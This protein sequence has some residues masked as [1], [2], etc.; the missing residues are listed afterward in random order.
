MK[1][2]SFVFC[3]FVAL[4]GQA[5]FAKPESISVSYFGE[6]ITHPGLKL[7]ANFNLKEWSKMKNADKKHSKELGKSLVL[8]PAIGFYYHRRYQTGLFLIPEG[9]YRSLNQK[10]LFHEFGLG[11]G[12]LRTFVPNTYEVTG[13]DEVRKVSAGHNY[14][15]TNFFFTIGKD[16][17]VAKEMPIAY[18]IK[19]QLMYAVPNFPKGVGYFVLEIGITYSLNQ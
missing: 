15:A 9:K 18:F 13:N 10:G 14:F 2:I 19:P 7:S 4:Q 1:I 8:S 6:M 3:V 16:L 5:Q 17:G 12:Y 11:L